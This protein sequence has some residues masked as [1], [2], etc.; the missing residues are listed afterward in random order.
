MIIKKFTAPT[1]TE[2][3]AKVREELGTE[4]IILSTRSQ[5]R[6]GVLDLVGKSLVEVTAAVDDTAPNG[7]GGNTSSI[8][9]SLTAPIAPA[10]ARLYP[11]ERP[12]GYEPPSRI[13]VS[14]LSSDVK[15]KDLGGRVELDRLLEDIL[16]L[17]RS[18]KILADSA[19]T[20]TLDGLPAGLRTLL[21][22]MQQSGLDDRISKRLIRQLLNELSGIEMADTETILKKTTELMLAGM[23]D[24]KPIILAGAKPRLVAFV[25]PTGSGKTTTIAK[26][27]ADFTLNQKK[28]VAVLTI[29]TRRVDAVGQLKAYC[30]IINIPLHIAYSPDELPGL[31]PGIMQTDVIL[32]DT[33]GSGPMDRA[34][35][36]E[37][38]EFLQRLAP[39]EVHL[40]MSVTTSLVE[41]KRIFE[42]FGMLKPNRLLFTKLDET[43]LFGTMLSFAVLSKKPISYVTFGQN[44]PGDFSPADS[45]E[46][47]RRTLERKPEDES[48]EPADRRR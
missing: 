27:A 19:A 24:V 32:V 18:V 21:S 12:A 41:M 34:Q 17:K 26:L 11:P 9:A 20:G 29:D 23:G 10:E 28:K 13:P 3:L 48:P 4:A 33:P 45:R 38:V 47:I 22:S 37:M 6:G 15:I 40:I 25:G 43:D 30:R 39:Q 2:A 44:V 8:S 36:N 42:N 7:R 35:M 46:L 14:R 16:E 31:M 5:K 1:M